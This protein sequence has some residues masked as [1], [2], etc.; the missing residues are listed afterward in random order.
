[1]ESVAF[2]GPFDAEHVEEIHLDHAPLTRVLAQ[3]RFEQLALFM[4]PD[5][6]APFVQEISNEYP[7][8]KQAHE[9]QVVVGPTGVSQEPSAAPLWQMRSQDAMW[10]VTISNGSLAMET[11]QY[12]SREDF[13]E[14]FLRV[15]R[16]FTISLGTPPSTRLGLRYTNQV[17]SDD[18]GPEELSSLIRPEAKGGMA[19]PVGKNAELKHSI[20]DAL[21]AVSDSFV[22]A[23]WGLLPAGTVLDPTM[24]PLP[25]RALILDLD[26]FTA[27]TGVLT[28][29]QDSNIRSLAERAY[30][31]FRWLVTDE[32]ITR[33]Q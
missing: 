22:Q 27:T 2:P 30:H 24:K 10:M 15:L 9:V 29:I 23:R 5:P 32:F 21:F 17:N 6:V 31:L 13:I 18:L 33:F 16:A 19:I 20:T 8:L 14:R 28:N 25:T 11:S 1:M 3:V 4:K 12:T 7:L 26:S